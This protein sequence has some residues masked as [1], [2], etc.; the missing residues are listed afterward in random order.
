MI[1]ARPWQTT[2][3][4]LG[5]FGPSLRRTRTVYHAFIRAGAGQ[6]RRPEL[7]GGGLVRSL[8]GDEAGSSAFWTNGSSA[9][10]SSRPACARRLPPSSNR[11]PECPRW[12]GWPQ[13][14]AGTWGSPR[15][16]SA[17]GAVAGSS[18]ARGGIAYLWLEVSGQSGRAA[19]EAFGLQPQ[20][21]YRAAQKGRNERRECERIAIR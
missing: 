14:S 8:G 12:T 17:Q 10:A 18:R 2:L 3:E 13:R 1:V 16:P 9:A 21:I 6:G 5:R 19:A 20:S 15:R 11:V 7:Q 4:V